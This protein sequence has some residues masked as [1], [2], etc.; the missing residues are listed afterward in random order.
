MVAHRFRGDYIIWTIVAKA[1]ILIK[2]DLCAIPLSNETSAALI[3][4]DQQE[5]NHSLCSGDTGVNGIT[6]KVHTNSITKETI[7]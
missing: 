2:G 5:L 1:K 3:S 6:A 7:C 4:T